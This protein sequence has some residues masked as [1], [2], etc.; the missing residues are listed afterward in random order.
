MLAA[1]TADLSQPD[2]RREFLDTAPAVVR[3]LAMT[4]QGIGDYRSFRE[5]EVC[6]DDE[7][8]LWQRIEVALDDRGRLTIALLENL[9][10]AELEDVL[11]DPVK[12][13]IQEIRSRVT[14]GFESM[15]RSD[16]ITAGPPTSDFITLNID[17]LDFLR[18]AGQVEFTFQGA[19]EAGFAASV[20]RSS[21]DGGGMD[22][23][24]G[25]ARVSG[26]FSF[27]AGWDLADDPAQVHVGDCTIE[28]WEADLNV[29]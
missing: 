3:V 15:D 24:Q 6:I 9:C 10:A 26:T 13:L 8:G 23:L 19:F 20:V 22:D 21:S 25:D 27:V 28:D 12:Q 5:A 2:I 7:D 4:E 1:A 14:T 17:S 11:Q 16:P 18:Y 29:G